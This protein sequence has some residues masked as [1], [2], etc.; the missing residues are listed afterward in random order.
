MKKAVFLYFLLSNFMFSQ[1]KKYKIFFSKDNITA[2]ITEKKRIILV[3][4]EIETIDLHDMVDALSMKIYSKQDDMLM[5]YFEYIKTSRKNGFLLVSDNIISQTNKMDNITQKISQ[6]KSVVGV[7]RYRKEH[8]LPWL[9]FNQNLLTVAQNYADY[10]V[11]NNWYLN[12]L[13]KDGHGHGFRIK[14]IIPDAIYC[15]ENLLLGP[16]SPSQTILYFAN[17]PIHKDNLLSKYVKYVAVGISQ[18]P[19]GDLIYV[20]NYC[21]FN[22]EYSE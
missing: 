4:N 17:S 5:D 6:I 21:H 18:F 16:I 11:K 13:D 2:T 3:L 14:K 7:N 9:L 8:K 19:N 20:Q 12:H 10:C 1:Q 22:N 15:A